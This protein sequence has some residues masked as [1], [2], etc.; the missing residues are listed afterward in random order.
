MSDE[1]KNN[2]DIL[3][4]LKL[5]FSAD[6]N[7]AECIEDNDNDNLSGDDLQ[8][9]LRS[10]F[11]NDTAKSMESVWNIWITSSSI[12]PVYIEALREEAF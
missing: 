10:R 2:Q 9:E 12:Q 5:S 7:N 6:N 3:E 8:A 4:Q 11:L 1:N